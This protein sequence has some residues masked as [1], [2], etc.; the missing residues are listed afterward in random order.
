M[1]V[2]QTWR[3][4]SHTLLTQRSPVFAN[5]SLQ[6]GQYLTSSMLNYAIRW[7]WTCEWT[8][9][10]FGYS[11]YELTGLCVHVWNPYDQGWGL[12]KV[13]ILASL[14]YVPCP[15]IYWYHHLCS[16]GAGRH[17]FPSG[18]ELLPHMS[19]LYVLLCHMASIIGVTGPHGQYYRS[20]WATFPAFIFVT[21]LLI[22]QSISKA[23][24][25]S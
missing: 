15:A 6:Q 12:A 23:T 4:L 25:I 7:G 19:S 18:Y 9:L 8:L 17:P 5:L 13:Y 3:F 20:C 22:F 2:A 1:I 21:T 11:W 24:C 14:M 16:M 10:E